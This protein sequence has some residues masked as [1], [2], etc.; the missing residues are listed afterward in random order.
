M[1]EQPD[2][3]QQLENRPPEEVQPG[4]G[5]GSLPEEGQIS[6][7]QPTKARPPKKFNFNI[8]QSVAGFL[9]WFLV[10]L[11]I[12]GQKMDQES[13][14]IC[15]GV[16]FLANI[17]AL[18]LLLIKLRSVGLGMLAALGVNLVISLILGL[19]NNALCF[20]PFYKNP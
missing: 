12:Y 1:T 13:L 3:S 14:M 19:F 16:L 15:G 17:G 10:T 5:E 6:S 2:S 9:G 4:G 18:I 7:E 11:P 20:I 8:W